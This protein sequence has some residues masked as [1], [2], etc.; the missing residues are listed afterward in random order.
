MYAVNHSNAAHAEVFVGM[1]LVWP[2]R[3]LMAVSSVSPKWEE[4]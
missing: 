2:I 3:K 1:L 4:E